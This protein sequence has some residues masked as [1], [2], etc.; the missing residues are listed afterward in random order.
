MRNTQV[1]ELLAGTRIEGNGTAF[2][3]AGAEP[4]MLLISTKRPVARW[5]ELSATE[6]SDVWALVDA[7]TVTPARVGFDTE[8]PDGVPWH[9]CLRRASEDAFTTLPEFVGGEEQRLL[10][11]LQ[12]ALALAD[13]ADLLSAFIQTSGVALLRDDL[14]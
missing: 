13:E 4:G 11:A 3:V 2:A 12:T 5:S 1:P 10:P 8:A 14:E 9:V 7:L 6:R